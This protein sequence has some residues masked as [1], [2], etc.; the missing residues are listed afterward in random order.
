MILLEKYYENPEILHIG[1]EE[2]RAYFIPFD[3][4]EKALENILNYFA[5]SNEPFVKD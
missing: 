2:P 3:S 5:S 1:C 4:E